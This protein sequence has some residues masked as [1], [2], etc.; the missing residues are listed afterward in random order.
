[1]MEWPADASIGTTRV[2]T[3]PLPPAMK[4]FNYRCA[5]RGSDDGGTM[6]LMR[7]VVTRLP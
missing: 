2:P 6:L 4:M 7:I 1:V 3:T 5:G